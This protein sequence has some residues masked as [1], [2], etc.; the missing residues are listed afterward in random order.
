[1][2]DEDFI[3]RESVKYLP[4]FKDIHS[5]KGV[6]SIIR[7]K[8]RYPHWSEKIFTDALNLPQCLNGP[9]A[10]SLF[11]NLINNQPP[12]YNDS[13][14]KHIIET[15]LFPLAY[16]A[17]V[18]WH[19]KH[20]IENILMTYKKEA[21]NT[22]HD[23]GHAWTIWCSFYE[24]LP[25]LKNTET[26]LFATERLV[27]FISQQF[28]K[29][30]GNEPQPTKEYYSDKQLAPIDFNTILD[31]CLRK[32]GFMGHNLLTLG[33]LLRHKSIINDTEFNAALFQVEQMANYQWNNP[34]FEINVPVDSVPDT[35]INSSTLEN[36]ILNLLKS[37][38]NDVHTLTMA[39]IAYD[40]WQLMD[41]R[42]RQVLKYY[43][44]IVFE[45]R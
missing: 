40:L 41:V 8:K 6:L 24:L 11:S 32:P 22:I 28:H 3:I 1:M 16:K 5:I 27:E 15:G 21:I 13:K 37:G 19:Q 34:A 14:T 38:I 39:D 42:Q 26:T 2:I 23:L 45:K 9:A 29:Y 36:T 33:Y 35:K 30:S 25:Y 12:T 18:D 20:G 10:T 31:L 44:D 17:G 7:F 43:L 4:A